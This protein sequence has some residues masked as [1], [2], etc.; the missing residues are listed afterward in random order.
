MIVLAVIMATASRAS[1]ASALHNSSVGVATIGPGVRFTTDTKL[2]V[3]F[4]MT[5][6]FSIGHAYHDNLNLD[7]IAFGGYSDN[8]TVVN[9]T[10]WGAPQE[11]ISSFEFKYNASALHGSTVHFNITMTNAADY[12]VVT[13]VDGMERSNYRISSTFFMLNWSSWS[14]PHF[15]NWTI[16]QAQFIGT[17]LMDMMTNAVWVFGTIMVFTL[18]LMGAWWLRKRRDG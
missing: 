16:T 3:T 10:A 13:R 18:T 17:N 9:I 15:F 14:G 6:T 1:F 7:G 5:K 8:P 12:S 11:S 2:T 4:Q